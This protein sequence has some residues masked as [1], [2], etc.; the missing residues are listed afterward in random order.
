MERFEAC[1]SGMWPNPQGAWVLY[2]DATVAI[3]DKD[4]RI[5][6]LE[7]QLRRI[8]RVGHNDDCLFCGFKDRQ[9][10]ESNVIEGTAAMS[11][12][13]VAEKNVPVKP[14][15]PPGRVL[16]EGRDPRVKKG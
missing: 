7:E 11:A 5:A 8:H 6:F 13:E 16:R 2:K 15:P 4:K 9:V 14:T 12:E 3:H 1:I 10:M